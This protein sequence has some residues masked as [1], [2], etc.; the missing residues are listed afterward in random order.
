MAKNLSSR[1][2]PPVLPGSKPGLGVF[3]ALLRGVNVGGNNMI[4]MG[5]LRKSFEGMGFGQVGT[6]INSGNILFKSKEND[7]RKLE[8]K[9]EK[10]LL[11]EYQLDSR[12]V[13]RT[14]PEMVKLVKSLPESWSTDSDWRYNVMFLR[15]TID[16]EEILAE[17]PVKSDI[18]RLEYRPGALLWSAKANN[19]SET[20]M[21]KLGSRKIHRDMTVRNLNT[22]RKLCDLMS[23]LAETDG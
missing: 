21:A 11:K 16:S 14:L 22:T 2:A 15:H 1:K 3:V 13:V 9:I 17:L 5:A 10:M 19:L 6:Y 8:T 23:K 18:E 20:S 12:V 7:A 4:S